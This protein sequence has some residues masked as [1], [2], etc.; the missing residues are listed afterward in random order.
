MCG[1]FGLVA[2]ADTF[3]SHGETAALLKQLYLFSESRGKE[4]AGIHI[5]LPASNKTWTLKSA[6]P[7]SEFIAS[8][9]Y[10]DLIGEVWAALDKNKGALAI[11][12]HS[13]LVTNGS[14]DDDR[15]NQPVAYGDVSVV[16]NGI[17]VNAGELWE[18]NPDLQRSAEVDTEIAAAFMAKSCA[19]QKHPAAATKEFLAQIEGSAS[20]AWVNDNS[21]FMVLAS[22]TGDLFY[23]VDGNKK[24]LTFASERYIL[25]Q[26]AKA[27]NIAWVKPQTGL[28]ITLDNIDIRSF[29]D[30]ED[31]APKP[32][33][34]NLTAH[35]NRVFSA[36]PAPAIINKNADENLIRYNAKNLAG[37]KRCTRCILP[38]TFPFIKFD[39]RGVC[40]YCHGYK[41]KYKNINPETAR[42]EF[43]ASL[44]K[45]RREG[46]NPDAIVPFSGGR[47]SCYGLHIIKKEFG[48]TPITFTYD[49][50]MVTDLARRN[51]ARVCGELGVQ[52]ILVSADIKKK[53]ENIRKN[54]AAW[55]KK[56][57]LGM[58]PLFMAGDK[59]FFTVVNELKAQ[60]GIKLDLWCANPLENT[61]F[62]SGFCGIEPDFDKH[63]LDYLSISR[64]IKLIGH[65]AGQFIKNPAYLNSSLL[66]SFSA[67]TSYYLSP[68]TDF[69]FIFNHMLWNEDEV[70]KTLLSTYNWET[71]PDSPSTWRIGDGTAPFYNYIYV[72]TCGF[73]EFDTFR[74]NQIREGMITREYALE[75]VLKENVPRTMSLKWYLETIG[76]DF[77]STI[78][79][80][81]ALDVMGLH[82]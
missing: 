14:A 73:S 54:V 42:R 43:I 33:Y 71:S 10:N 23:S 24:F 3:I 68:R 39:G 22:N 28:Y 79:R 61:D 4:S 52:N 36:K 7:A 26:A 77:D 5:Y 59:H 65:F 35:E 74:S 30:L 46:E 34:S 38:E 57:D 32:V 50:G 37:L 12:A 80:I 53:R 63:R 25:A 44:Q 55:L 17:I 82:N 9:E 15:N 76:L 58:V 29:E 16:H 66:D 8:Q 21:G 45:Y 62:K 6:H 67:F 19:A 48:L 31:G 75:N 49:W 64:K 70:N 41:T 47:D 56:P 13:R 11:I 20:L 27:E 2:P 51:I 69:Y 1:I 72:T 18:K 60:T 40:N 78:K 81:N